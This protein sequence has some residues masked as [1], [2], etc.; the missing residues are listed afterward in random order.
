[1]RKYFGII[2]PWL[3]HDLILIRT[4]PNDAAASYEDDDG[5]DV[6]D[7]ADFPAVFFHIYHRYV[8]WNTI[9]KS[10]SQESTID[11][12]KTTCIDPEILSRSLRISCRFFVPKIFLRVV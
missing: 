8:S 1:M 10:K 4:I 3:A 5:N 6:D 12:G 2:S 11:D 9:D 7:V